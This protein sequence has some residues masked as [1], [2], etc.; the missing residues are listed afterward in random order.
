[1]VSLV[2]GRGLVG[3]DRQ[4]ATV[5]ALVDVDGRVNAIRHANDVV[6]RLPPGEGVLDDG[7]QRR[8]PRAVLHHW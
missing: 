4:A 2:K 3:Q 7:D 6:K 5:L 8:P 1:V